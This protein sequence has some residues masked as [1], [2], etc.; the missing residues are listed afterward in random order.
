MRRPTSSVELLR[1]RFPDAEETAT[2]HLLENIPK[3][4]WG[5]DYNIDLYN[6][7]AW[8]TDEQNETFMGLRGRMLK[9]PYTDIH[10]E[11]FEAKALSTAA[12]QIVTGGNGSWSEGSGNAGRSSNEKSVYQIK[13]QA[14]H[15]FTFELLAD[16]EAKSGVYQVPME[17]TYAD[18]L[19]K[20]YFKNSTIGLIVGAVV[21]GKDIISSAKQKKLYAK[22]VQ[23]WQIAYNTYYDRTGWI[24]GDLSND[25]N[26]GL[27]DGRCGDADAPSCDNLV[28]QLKAV[29]LEPPPLGETGICPA[30]T[31]PS[32]NLLAVFNLVPIPPL[33]GSRVMM[34]LLP[35]LWAYRYSRLEPY[36]LLIVFLAIWLGLFHRVIFPVSIVFA[37]LLGF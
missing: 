36:G 29:G 18:E 8:T 26:Q 23:S 34:G 19:G 27:R 33:D 3:T 15:T 14:D 37:K 11:S 13:A 31:I 10:T 22:Y 21:K 30:P 7:L 1:V 32:D 25:D 28:S 2:V 6:V 9:V 5:L 17:I 12:W 24:L 4:P 35:R 20:I 16:P